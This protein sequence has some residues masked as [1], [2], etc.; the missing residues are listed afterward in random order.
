MKITVDSNFWDRQKYPTFGGIIGPRTYFMGQIKVAYFFPLMN[1][2]VYINIEQQD[3]HIVQNE[4][5]YV[6][7]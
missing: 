1:A 5:V 3:I 2:L 4:N 6:L 7:C